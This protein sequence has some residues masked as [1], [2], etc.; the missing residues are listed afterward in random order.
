MLESVKIPFPLVPLTTFTI[1]HQLPPGFI[2]DTM[3]TEGESSSDDSLSKPAPISAHLFRSGPI[4]LKAYRAACERTP[5]QPRRSRGSQ[6]RAFVTED[7]RSS[8]TNQIQDLQTFQVS[9][10]GT[11]SR[12]HPMGQRIQTRPGVTEQWETSIPRPLTERC[13]Q[14]RLES[15]Y[16]LSASQDSELNRSPVSRPEPAD[17]IDEVT[18][19][20]PQIQRPTKSKEL[21]QSMLDFHS[22]TRLFGVKKK[23]KKRFIAR[24]ISTVMTRTSPT[25]SDTDNMPTVVPSKGNHKI[26]KKRKLPTENELVLVPVLGGRE[27][28]EIAIHIESDPI[29]DTQAS[30]PTKPKRTPQTSS[31]SRRQ[32]LRSIQKNLRLPLRNGS[33]VH[34]AFNFRALKNTLPA[35][36]SPMKHVVGEVFEN[37]ELVLS[38]RSKRKKTTSRSA[39]IT[40]PTLDLINAREQKEPL[41]T[42]I[43]LVPQQ[44]KDMTLDI[45]VTQ[46]FS[47]QIENSPFIGTELMTPDNRSQDD[48]VMISTKEF[49]R[50]HPAIQP[51]P[52]KQIRRVSFSNK[53]QSQLLSV[54]A[55]IRESSDGE[56]DSEASESRD[57]E[58]ESASEANESDVEEF[59]EMNFTEARENTARNAELDE[60]EDEELLLETANNGVA[61]V[62]DSYLT[63]P[64]Q[65]ARMKSSGRLNEVPEDCIE[66]NSSSDP[67]NSVPGYSARYHSSVTEPTS[68]SMSRPLKSI[69][70]NREVSSRQSQPLRAASQSIK[71]HTAV[72]RS[73][74]FSQAQHQLNGPL[75]RHSIVPRR[76]TQ[77]VPQ[78]VADSNDRENDTGSESCVQVST[79]A[80]VSG[81]SQYFVATSAIP[82]LSTNFPTLLPN[83]Q[84]PAPN[85]RTLVRRTSQEF[86]TTS[87]RLRRT[88]SLPFNPPFLEDRT[89]SS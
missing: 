34:S 33:S 79:P 70:K 63:R 5:A 58:T 59:E 65:L 30:A 32:P 41:V 28:P 88:P 54:T 89:S 36:D 68:T 75:R 4:T 25:S 42:S 18:T 62:N 9:P 11:Q 46:C 6:L 85:L 53:V 13:V 31:Q 23:V 83:I 22:I 12:N 77:Q 19:S 86:G 14:N 10:A 61:V 16:D 81:S 48:V 50:I 67:A 82:R 64:G 43:P 3:E 52:V 27:S 44:E 47:E 72:E 38:P 8:S 24:K 60:I 40:V 35:F 51:R 7:E 74:Y 17:D 56:D 73:S 78:E 69:L 1:N 37:Q 80:R 29:E 2:S 84:T 20:A 21:A 71:V 57:S 39:H 45:D 76:Y 87:A 26:L 49:S 15:M 66:V 55:P